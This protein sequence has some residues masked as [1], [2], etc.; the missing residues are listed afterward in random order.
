MP[1]TSSPPPSPAGQQVIPWGSMLAV[2]SMLA[3][4]AH[5]LLGAL[6]LPPLHL[7]YSSELAVRDMP[8]LLVIFL[9]APLLIRI[10]G[11]ILGGN[12]GA[13]FLGAIELVAAT[14]LDQYLAAV[15]IILMLSGGQALEAYAMRRASSVLRALAERMP[16]TAH[17]KRDSHIEEIALSEIA[18]GDDIVVFPHETAPVDGVVVEGHGA[19]DESYLTGE[20][21]QVTKAPGAAVLSGAINGASA[22]TIRAEKLA[23]DSRYAQIMGVMQE[24]EQKRPALRRL[25]DQLGGIFAIFALLASG[26]VWLVTDD[27]LRF[28][29]VLI[30]ATP[31][32]LIIAIPITIVGAISMAARR[33]IIIKDPTVLERLPTCRT[34]IFD[35]TGTLTYGKPELTEIIPAPGITRDEILARAASLESYSKHPLASAILEAAKKSNLVRMEASSVSE[36]P[37]QGLTGIIAGHEIS[38]THRRKLLQLAPNMAA[39]LPPTAAGLEC[40]ILQDGAYAATFQFRDAPRAEGKSF[41]GHLSPAHQFSK[42]MLVSGDRESEVNYLAALLGITE[43]KASQSPEQKVAIVRA[44]T[45]LAPTLFMGDGINDAPALAS[46]TVGIAFGQHSS[47]TAEAAGAVIMENS[48]VKVD[49]LIHISERLRVIALQSAIGGI[50]LSLLGMGFAAAGHITPVMGAV[51]Q[52]VID[53]LAIANA[54]R[55]TLGTRIKTDI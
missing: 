46:A 9:S 39:L 50:T 54:L 40:V 35:K 11:K 13:D 51:I 8:L 41:I 53:L 42:V 45:A 16:A 37:G 25:G 24:A 32:P 14:L 26:I 44:E 48:L 55:L 22:L 7:P 10:G 38:V 17:R 1:S 23:Q 43:T 34:A 15:L 12:I 19:M 21:Y 31:C 28:L 27:A 49:E 5:L 36:K 2:A 47:V 20:P 30:I 52:E 33:G 3:I 4:A 29:S 18:V 6:K